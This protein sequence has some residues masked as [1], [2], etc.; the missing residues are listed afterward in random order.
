M[1]GRAPRRR[2][3]LQHHDRHDD[4]P[5]AIEEGLTLDSLRFIG[6]GGEAASEQQ[7]AEIRRAFPNAQLVYTYG[8]TEA[9]IVATHVVGSTVEE[10]GA[11]MPVGFPLPFVDVEIVDESDRPVPV[12][13]FG[14]ISVTGHH[15][16]G[17]LG[18]AC[19]HR[20][21]LRGHADGRR[22]MRTGDRGRF[23]PDGGSSSPGAPTA[24]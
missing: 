3:D 5:G 1:D 4:H 13:E 16:P 21:A 17:L 6:L 20:R 9:G 2:D 24:G 22:T 7:F 18:R 8:Q 10:P 19:A 12:G 15:G 11:P 14:E 23:R